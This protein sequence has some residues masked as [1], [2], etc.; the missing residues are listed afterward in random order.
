M[1]HQI[2]TAN[3]YH[4]TL[5][6]SK[7]PQLRSAPAPGSHYL[8]LPSPGFRWNVLD[9][10]AGNVF[11]DPLS[12][13]SRCS[14]E[15]ASWHCIWQR[16]P[17][18][19]HLRTPPPP[20]SALANAAY[21]LFNLSKA[22]ERKGSMLQYLV[23]TGVTQVACLGDAGWVGGGSQLGR[24]SPLMAPAEAPLLI[25]ILGAH[26]TSTFIYGGPLEADLPQGRTPLRRGY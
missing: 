9:Y 5:P 16:F 20:G 22:G 12:A 10:G 14:H 1:L 18:Q 2:V 4:L 21:E 25:G 3:Y 23:V 7:K 26:A 13:G 19:K 24:P 8:P 6:P 11:A 15:R 17:Q